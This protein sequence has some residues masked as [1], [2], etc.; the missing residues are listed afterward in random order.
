MEANWLEF[1]IQFAMISKNNIRILI[2]IIH[3]NIRL[4]HCGHVTGIPNE[5]EG[6]WNG[7][8]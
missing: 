8:L 7:I 4:G 3:R 2:L 1:M 5:V 6:L